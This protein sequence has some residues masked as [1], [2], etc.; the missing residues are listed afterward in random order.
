MLHQ[1]ITRC[2]HHGTNLANRFVG[3]A[4]LG[5]LDFL[6]RHKSLKHPWGGP[7]NGQRF[8]QRIFFDLLYHY[9]IKAI[10]ETGTFR[11]TTTE[12]FAATSLPVYTVE[13]HLRFHSYSKMRFFFEQDTIHLYYNDSR[14]FLRSLSASPSIPKDHVFF[15]LDAHWSEDLPLCE[16][17]E[18]IFMN[19]KRPVIMV[20]DFQVPDSDYGYDDYGTGKVLDLNCISPVVSA[21]K[22]SV[23]FP[24]VNASEETGSKRG[25]VVLCRET[26][27]EHLEAKVK[28]LVRVKL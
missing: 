7:F 16:E 13:A 21:H 15:Y 1:F 28:T 20:D 10:V 22:A 11:G 6:R 27:G 4:N 17:L 14:A 25:C 9:P 19:W 26:A 5:R 24:A 18:I 23:F 3:G 8:R 12:L 2:K